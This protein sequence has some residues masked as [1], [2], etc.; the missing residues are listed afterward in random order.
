MVKRAGL[1]ILIVEDDPIIATD[2][3]SL[4]LSEGFGV[5]GVAKNALRAYDLLKSSAPNFAI[6]DIYLGT[7]PSGIEIAESIHDRYQIPYIFLTSFSDEKTLT[8]AQEQGPYGY[9]VK[10][11]QEKTLIT[12]IAVA[13]SNYQRLQQQ[14]GINLSRFNIKLTEQEENI[15]RLLCEG[16]SYKQICAR[17]FISMNTLKFHV[18]NIYSKF[19]V[20]G[21]AELTALL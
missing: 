11:F 6:L 5:V 8:A 20:A 10:P 1:K 15:C 18:K 21:R 19:N 7:G 16:A 2:I 12:T 4:L 9:L 17:L 3:K 14:Q 13:W